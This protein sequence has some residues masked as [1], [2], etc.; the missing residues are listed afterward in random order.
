MNAA[1]EKAH[2]GTT[3]SCLSYGTLEFTRGLRYYHM[4]KLLLTATQSE[5][6]KEK[7]ERKLLQ[8]NTSKQFMDPTV[9]F[10]EMNDYQKYV[11]YQGI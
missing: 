4:E 8:I 7:M 11:T 6:N 9:T 2:A 1:L 10:L 3:H 5:I